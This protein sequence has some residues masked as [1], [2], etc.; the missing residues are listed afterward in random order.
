MNQLFLGRVVPGIPT[1]PYDAARRGTGCSLCMRLRCRLQSCHQPPG[2]G[3]RWL[4][5]DVRLCRRCRTN[6]HPPT[7]QMTH[8]R[9][10]GKCGFRSA[11]CKY[12]LF[13]SGTIGHGAVGA[14][15]HAGSSE[16]SHSRV[17]AGSQRSIRA[18]SQ[19][20]MP[21]KTVH[22]QMNYPDSDCQLRALRFVQQENAIK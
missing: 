13:A 20:Q 3:P 9:A 12:G 8:V 7:I 18:K 6:V 1:R 4:C 10:L 5:D 17:S 11:C 14:P 2:V 21:W 19:V 22:H 16:L 15:V